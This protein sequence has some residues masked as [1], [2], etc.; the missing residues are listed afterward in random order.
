MQLVLRVALAICM[1]PMTAHADVDVDVASHLTIFNEPSSANQGL[2]VLHPQTEVSAVTGDFAV[3]AG[4][5][6]DVV[7]GSTPR[8]YAPGAA[9][10]AGAGAPDAA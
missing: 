6:M 5:E 8:V 3:S 9:E 1:L 4:Y 10:G 2:R 7:S